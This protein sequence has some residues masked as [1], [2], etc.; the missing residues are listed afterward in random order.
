MDDILM[1]QRRCDNQNALRSDMLLL[2]GKRKLQHAR[3]NSTL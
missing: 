2:Q 1:H 3:T